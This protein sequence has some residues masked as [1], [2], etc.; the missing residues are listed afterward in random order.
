MSQRSGGG[1]LSRI[2]G[3]IATFVFIGIG[4]GLIGYGGYMSW[5][6]HSGIPA[7]VKLL[8]CHSPGRARTA[9]CSA[10]WIQANGTERT[11]TVHD[12]ANNVAFAWP[13]KTVDVRIR[14]DQAYTNSNSYGAYGIFGGIALTGVGIWLLLPSRR[15]RRE[16]DPGYAG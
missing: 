6:G 11:V 16:A 5:V 7:Q 4:M 15:K 14:G 2:G 1:F 10:T 13:R 9:D 12:V 3:V 8:K